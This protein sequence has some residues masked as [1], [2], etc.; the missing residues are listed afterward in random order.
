MR[1][2]NL[3]VKIFGDHHKLLY[4]DFNMRPE[5]YSA[6]SG[7]WFVGSDFAHIGKEHVA[8]NVQEYFS[9]SMHIS[10]EYFVGL[11]TLSS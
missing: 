8:E 1:Q 11:L 10:C 2:F 6:L 9:C 4:G 5:L 7:L 3:P